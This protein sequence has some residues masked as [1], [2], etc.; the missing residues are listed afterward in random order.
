MRV[1]FT[2]VEVT[3]ASHDGGIDGKGILQVND[4]LDV[5]SGIS[6]QKIQRSL[7]DRTWCRN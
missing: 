4:F 1:D 7:W 6:V 2:K 5:P 3:K